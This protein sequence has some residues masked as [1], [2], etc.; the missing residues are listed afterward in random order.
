MQIN[1]F[2]RD[3]TTTPAPA[4]R[5]GVVLCLLVLLGLVA[6]PAA[7]FDL[8]RAQRF[9]LDNGLELLILEEPAL[10]LVSVQMLYRV[11]ARNEQVGKTGLAHFLEHM[12]FRSSKHFP[13]TGH[14][15][16]DQRVAEAV[17]DSIEQAHEHGVLRGRV[18]DNPSV[19]FSVERQLCSSHVRRR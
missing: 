4:R 19:L 6:L 17:A 2:E 18:T 8:A 13:D 5:P 7:P 3:R 1:R 15:Y 12:A 9:E 16:E 10:P 11:G 14:H